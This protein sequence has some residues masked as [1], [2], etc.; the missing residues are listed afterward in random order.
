MSIS[1]VTLEWAIQRLR[2][3]WVVDRLK[4]TDVP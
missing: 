3:D 2:M 4:M 1:W